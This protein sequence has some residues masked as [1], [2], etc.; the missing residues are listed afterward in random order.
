MID[1]MTRALVGSRFENRRGDL[2]AEGYQIMFERFDDYGAF[3]KL[4]HRN[5]NIVTI[6]CDYGKR[7]IIQKT[8]GREVHAETLC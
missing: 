3:S 5:G 1:L 7:T 2:L 6:S 4:R 8:N